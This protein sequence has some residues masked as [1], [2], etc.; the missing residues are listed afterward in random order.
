MHH[1]VR[2]GL[3]DLELA[4]CL[5]G[6][7]FKHLSILL[8]HLNNNAPSKMAVMRLSTF[9]ALSSSSQGS[10]I[11]TVYRPIGRNAKAP[12][13]YPRCSAQLTETALAEPVTIIKVITMFMAMITTNAQ[14]WLRTQ[15]RDMRHPGYAFM[16]V[17]SPSPPGTGRRGP[18]GAIQG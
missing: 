9:I 15:G 2:R 11:P 8:D 14:L 1:H 18:G 13:R 7:L 4:G 6:Y 16:A 3:Y 10:T 5:R 12:P 17:T